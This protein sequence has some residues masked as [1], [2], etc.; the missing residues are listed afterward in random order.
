MH[1]FF[2][3]SML[4]R[5]VSIVVIIIDFNSLLIIVLFVLTCNLNGFELYDPLLKLQLACLIMACNHHTFKHFIPH[6][7]WAPRNTHLTLLCLL[8]LY[9]SVHIPLISYILF[10]LCFLQKF[11]SH[12]TISLFA[13]LQFVWRFVT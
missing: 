5:N 4:Y 1:G 6:P 13:C 11:Q 9:M 7:F 12:L 8:L 10:I 3:R 2:M